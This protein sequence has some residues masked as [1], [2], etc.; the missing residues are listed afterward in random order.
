MSNILRRLPKN[1]Y[2]KDF[3]IGDLHGCYELLMETLK[4]VNFDFEKDRVIAV[5][6]LVDRGPESMKCLELVYEP[7][8][9]SVMGNHEA[10]MFDGV[11]DGYE[12][13]FNC[14]LTNGGTWFMDQ[15]STSTEVEEFK[16]LL[17]DIRTRMPLAYEV[18][19][20]KGLVGIIHADAPSL[21]EEVCIRDLRMQVLWG[22]SRAKQGKE[23]RVSGVDHVYAGHTPLDNAPVTY[24]SITYMDTGAVWSGK[25]GILQIQ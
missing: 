8:F 10:M 22:R 9:Y 14:W 6:D 15:C 17:E 3:V 4:E 1:T 12:P 23:F 20:D 7:W 13:E 19:T 5:G 16:L 11:I 18:E 2:G 24:G 21:W 25:L